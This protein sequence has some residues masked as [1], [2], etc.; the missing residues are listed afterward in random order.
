MF[1]AIAGFLPREEGQDLAEYC[2]ITA[3]VALV[4]GAILFHVS[5]GMNGIWNAGNQTLNRAGSTVE[6]NGLSGR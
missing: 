6:A 5:G 1:R 2:L 3:L 4:A